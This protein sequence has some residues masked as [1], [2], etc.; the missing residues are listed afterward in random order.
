MTV[1][2]FLKKLVSDKT[3]YSLEA[4]DKK[5]I[6]FEGVEKFIY[7]KLNSSK[8]KATKTTDDYDKTVREKISYCVH[9]NIPIHLDLSTG[10]TKNPHAVSAPG[11]DWAEVFNVSYLREYLKPI[12]AG[13]PKGVTLEYFSVALF[14]EKVNHIPQQDVDLYDKQFAELINYFQ[15]FLP[16][17]FTL[18]YSRLSDRTSKKEVYPLMDDKIAELRRDWA[19]LPE[20]VKKEKLFRAERN[21]LFSGQELPRDATILDAALA[22]DS[23]VGECWTK[24]ATPIWYEQD[25]ISLG[26]R[27]TS[28]WA[29][30]V[31]SAPAS[32]VNFWSGVGVLSKKANRYIPAILSPKQYQ[33]VSAGFSE[34]KVD[35]FSANPVLAQKLS[36]IK[37]Y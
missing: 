31:R 34:E 25:D 27:Y 26:H 33:E 22:H 2:D 14:E 24:A 10:A 17:N 3:P 32:T 16:Q 12:A 9:Q 30:H 6:Q 18:R 4:E 1:N 7:R 37:V 20:E 21:I 11:I 36:S 35:I 19:K 13:Y 23:F 15:E 8:Y 28:G 5:T 29:I